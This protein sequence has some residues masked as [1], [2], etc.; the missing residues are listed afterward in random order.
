MKKKILP[1]IL[2]ANFL[3]LESDIIQ[4]IEAGIDSLH[5]DIMDGH[6]VPN[7]SI[8]PFILKLL[9][10]RFAD[11]FYDVHLM[12]TNPEKYITPFANAGADLLNFHIEIGD[13]NKIETIISDIKKL[14]KKVGLTIN[15]NTSVE[16]L[17]PFCKEVDLI[18]VMTVEPGFGG[19]SFIKSAAEKIKKLSELKKKHGFNYIIEIDGGL[20]RQTINDALVFGAE[21]FVLGSAIFEQNDIFKETEFYLNF[22]K[23]KYK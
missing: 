21:W 8:G 20:N 12:I 19:Q 15:P 23:N 6:F 10:K 1:S 16:N 14:N 4:T 2:S 9:K 17:L 13:K 11:L 18:L 7:I 22:I 3:N 5:I